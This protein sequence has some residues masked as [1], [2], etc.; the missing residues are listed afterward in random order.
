MDW[1]EPQAKNLEQ[2]RKLQRYKKPED[3]G[4]FTKNFQNMKAQRDED[5]NSELYSIN[6]T[7]KILWI[8]YWTVKVTYIH[9]DNNQGNKIMQ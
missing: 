1:Y 4:T 6:M 2:V 9:Q 8:E 3:Q 7:H 5:I